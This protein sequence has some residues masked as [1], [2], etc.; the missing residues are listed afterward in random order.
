M[1]AGHSGPPGPGQLVGEAESHCLPLSPCSVPGPG[2]VCPEGVQGL[3]PGPVSPPGLQE[4]LS[5]P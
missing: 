4:G 1:C 5:G 2:P 3:L